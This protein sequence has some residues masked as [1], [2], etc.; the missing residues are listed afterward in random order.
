MKPPSKSPLC[1]STSQ[2]Q[3][4]HPFQTAPAELQTVLVSHLPLFFTIDHKMLSNNKIQSFL[5]FFFFTLI[6]AVVAWW[7]GTAGHLFPWLWWNAEWNGVVCSHHRRTWISGKFEES[8]K[9]M[10]WTRHKLDQ[11]KGRSCCNMSDC[12]DW[13]ISLQHHS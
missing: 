7:E 10:V 2:L 4:T 8:P 11:C 12:A 9:D 13:L 6:K 3:V 5:G 1:L